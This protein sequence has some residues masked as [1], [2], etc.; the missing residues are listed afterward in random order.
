MLNTLLMQHSAERTM[1]ISDIIKYDPDGGYWDADTG[2]WVKY[3]DME[4]V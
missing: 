2:T 1:M 3:D 4:G